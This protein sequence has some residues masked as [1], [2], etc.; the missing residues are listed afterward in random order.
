MEAFLLPKTVSVSVCVC[1]GGGGVSRRDKMCVAGDIPTSKASVCVCV[2]VCVC[3]R[4]RQ[5]QSA[6][7][8]MYLTF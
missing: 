5:R 4:E 3:E 6:C 2:C 7:V 1:G 8:S